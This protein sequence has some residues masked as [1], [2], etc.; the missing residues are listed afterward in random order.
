MDTRQQSVANTYKK[1]RVMTA[2]AE[3]L[4]LM[5]YNGCI[6]KIKIAVSGVNRGDI[7]LA[8]D[9]ILLSQAIIRELKATLNMDYEVAHEMSKMYDFIL[10]KLIEG[11]IKKETEPLEIAKSLVE[12]FRDTWFEA[13]KESSKKAN[14][15]AI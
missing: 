11:N 8:H 15:N 12:D 6:K 9:N 14:Y 10:S 2:S 4:T 7:K 5:L 1:Q 13:M 3:E